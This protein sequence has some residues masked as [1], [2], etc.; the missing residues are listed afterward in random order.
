M[1]S[2]L[3]DITRG[4]AQVI[5]N[6]VSVDDLGEDIIIYDY[7]KD[8]GHSPSVVI[9]PDKANFENAFE[10][11]SDEWLFNLCIVVDTKAGDDLA[12]GVLK[13]LADGHGSCSIRRSIA[14]VPQLGL[15]D[16][17]ATVYGLKGYGG[18][19][20]WNDKPHIGAVLLAKV[21]LV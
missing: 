3:D 5:N 20:P 19:Y 21:R 7:V 4:L 2:S 9:L 15:P 17:V 18:K 8:L 12:Q 1:T 11:G 16:V 14:D 6:G 13:K 10:R